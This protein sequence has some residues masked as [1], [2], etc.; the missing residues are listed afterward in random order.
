ML[1]ETVQRNCLTRD[2]PLHKALRELLGEAASGW[3]L[4]AIMLLQGLNTGEALCARGWTREQLLMLH[5]PNV[6]EAA[7]AAEAGYWD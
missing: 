4:R 1:E 7:H 3:V 5:E 6:G 2:I